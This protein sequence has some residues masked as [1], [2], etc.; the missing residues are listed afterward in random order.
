M[1]TLEF[2]LAIV[3]MLVLASGKRARFLGAPAALGL[4]YFREQR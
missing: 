1:T 2:I 3:A 4:P